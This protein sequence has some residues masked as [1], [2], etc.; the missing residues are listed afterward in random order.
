MEG[1]AAAPTLADLIESVRSHEKTVRVYG[2]DAEGVVAEL[3]EYFAS[4]HVSVEWVSH[5]RLRAEVVDA[6]DVLA[7]VDG[8]AL[9]ALLDGPPG[10]D[11]AYGPLLEALDDTTFSAYDRPRMVRAAREIEDRAFRVGTGTLHAGF[12]RLSALADQRETYRALGALSDLEV[13]VY[14]EPDWSPPEGRVTVHATAAPEISESWFVVYDGGGEGQHCALLAVE[15]SPGEFEGF[16][17]YDRELVD[18]ALAA[19]ARLW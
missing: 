1:E 13:H 3:R 9:R 11:P 18:D 10:R 7:S 5:G 4:Q 14:G 8:E 2:P 6:G 15:R 16:W 17:T 12:Q 19:L